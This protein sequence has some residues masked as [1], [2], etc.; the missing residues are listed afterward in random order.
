MWRGPF[1]PI[2]WREFSHREALALLSDPVLLPSEPT[3]DHSIIPQCRPLHPSDAAWDGAGKV[4]GATEHGAVL[5][6]NPLRLSY[7]AG[8]KLVNDIERI[9][10]ACASGLRVQCLVP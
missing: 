1:K 3:L 7:L 10:Y 4:I 5:C 2:I 9:P 8:P 6:L